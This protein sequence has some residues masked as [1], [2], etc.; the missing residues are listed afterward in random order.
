MVVYSMQ[1]DRRD[2]TQ[3]SP[4]C[5]LLDGNCKADDLTVV[6]RTLPTS[7]VNVS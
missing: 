7:L 2:G 3:C 6:M 4:D 1:L 5:N